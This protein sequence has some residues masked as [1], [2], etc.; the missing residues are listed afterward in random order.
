MKLSYKILIIITCVLAVCFPL[1]LPVY[2]ML[3][4]S[5]STHTSYWTIPGLNPQLTDALIPVIMFGIL[6]FIGTVI[7]F[8]PRTN[9][10]L[11]KYSY[12]ILIIGTCLTIG[13]FS[14]S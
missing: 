12:I 9:Y 7:F 11:M 6:L 5:D 4:S 2:M 10:T 8:L 3:S 14:F 13:G 1:I